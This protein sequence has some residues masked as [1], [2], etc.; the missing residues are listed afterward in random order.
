MTCRGDVDTER[1]ICPMAD[2]ATE[3]RHPGRGLGV[4]VRARR[5]LKPEPSPV[6]LPPK[7]LAL[8]EA[9]KFNEDRER[10]GRRRNRLAAP[11]ALTKG[12]YPG[13]MREL[14]SSCDVPKKARSVTGTHKDG[15]GSRKCLEQFEVKNALPGKVFPFSEVGYCTH[16]NQ[17]VNPDIDNLG[18]IEVHGSPGVGGA[19]LGAHAECPW[20]PSARVNVLGTL[21]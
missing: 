19:G 14:T 16:T 3:L 9:T 8:L 4:E 15:H 7:T 13:T 12:V 21:G 6:R 17:D 2:G 18:R 1:S 11:E 20:V 10:Q 5:Q